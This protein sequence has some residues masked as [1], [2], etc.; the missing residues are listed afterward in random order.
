MAF[1]LMLSLRI[2]LFI[3]NIIVFQYI[4]ITKIILTIVTIFVSSYVLFMFYFLI[5]EKIVMKKR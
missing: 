4:D 1:I 3:L 2:I 5:R